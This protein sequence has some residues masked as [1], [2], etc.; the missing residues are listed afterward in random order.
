[1]TMS[2][3]LER[4]ID[5][6]M[7]AP[8]E[9]QPSENIYL[10]D[11]FDPSVYQRMLQQ[12]PHDDKYDDLTHPD[13]LLPDG[14]WAR[15]LLALYNETYDRLEGEER[16]F[17]SEVCDDLASE[18]LQ[19]AL[20]YKFE[21][22]IFERFG[23]DIPDMVTVPILYRDYPGYQI[24]IHPDSP[25]KVITLQF[26]L[27]SDDSQIHLGTTFHEKRGE[28]FVELKTNPF[29]P[30]SAYAF[31][32]TDHS[33]H[34]VKKMQENESIRNTLALTVYIKGH[35]YRQ[36]QRQAQSYA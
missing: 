9:M 33:W 11:V 36:V 8:L 7:A 29:R 16:S 18:M 28:S 23:N 14:R 21:D 24:S 1:M 10:Q 31:V 32:R 19:K 35:E 5:K 13:A 25:T 34:S 22:R 2:A 30:N 15:K 6:I 27:P 17:W 20:L 12:L 4:L 3:L 26:Y